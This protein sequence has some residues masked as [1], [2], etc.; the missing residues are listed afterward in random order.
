MHMHSISINYLLR[1]VC[2]MQVSTK[3]LLWSIEVEVSLKVTFTHCTLVITD[4][5]HTHII[6]GGIIEV[7]NSAIIQKK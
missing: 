3:T 6:S 5:T 2:S 7:S 1:F 4:E